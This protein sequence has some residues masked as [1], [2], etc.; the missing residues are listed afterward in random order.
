MT[1]MFLELLIV[2]NAAFAVI[3]FSASGY[4]QS[5]AK[6]QL[7]CGLTKCFLCFLSWG[8]LFYDNNEVF[9]NTPELFG[10]CDA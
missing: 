9:A 3:S 1:D 6:V 5:G 7:S 4:A 2:C 8:V 10:V